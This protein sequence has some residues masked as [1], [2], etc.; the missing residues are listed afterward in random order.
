MASQ[1][2]CMVSVSVS[3]E[4]QSASSQAFTRSAISC[5]SA[6]E[7]ARRASSVGNVVVMIIL[8]MNIRASLQRAR[9]I[10]SVIHANFFIS[11][12]EPRKTVAHQAERAAVSLHCPISGNKNRGRSLEKRPR[13]D[14]ISS[15][16]L[17]LDNPPE[18]GQSTALGD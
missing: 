3:E 5:A 8:L 9:H 1:T 18:K 14:C 6:S 7:G 2:S 10:N 11:C 4:P 16:L 17:G 15:V 13:S 12:P